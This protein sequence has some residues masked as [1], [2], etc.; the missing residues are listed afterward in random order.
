MSSVKQLCIRGSGAFHL[1]YGVNT[2]ATGP[3]STWCVM[4]IL[5]GMALSRQSAWEGSFTAAG[6]S[7]ET[8][9]QAATKRATAALAA[10]KLCLV[11]THRPATTARAAHSSLQ[12]AMAPARA[13]FG[14]VWRVSQ[15]TQHISVR[16][17]RLNSVTSSQSVQ[18]LAKELCSRWMKMLQ[19][20]IPL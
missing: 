17:I 15:T 5:A 11:S 12:R 13:L 10:R 18:A 7:W 19:T 4:V 6:N 1:C 9:A 2:L 20:S 14:V 3:T 16:M 8:S